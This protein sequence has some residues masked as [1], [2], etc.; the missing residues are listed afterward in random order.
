MKRLVAIIGGSEKNIFL[1]KNKI[2]KNHCIFASF[3][4]KN[5]HLV[6]LWIANGYC[7][8]II[9]DFRIELEKDSGV[10]GFGCSNG[11]K[12]VYYK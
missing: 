2:I 9:R 7:R 11:F 12:F 4:E 3:R 6:L 1:R 10:K 8:A 5:T